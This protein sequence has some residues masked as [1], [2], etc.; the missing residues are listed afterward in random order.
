MRVSVV[1]PTFNRAEI[2][3]KTIAAYL[4]QAGD[5]R[6]LEILVSTTVVA[7]PA[8]RSKLAASVAAG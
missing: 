2:L 3:R 4:Q 7:D 1:I 6:I 5:H 8:T